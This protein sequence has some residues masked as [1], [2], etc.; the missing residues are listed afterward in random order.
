MSP[1]APKGRVGKCPR[2]SSS[3]AYIDSLPSFGQ[4]VR[5]ADFGSLVSCS[6][7][8]SNSC[9]NGSRARDDHAA[10]EVTHDG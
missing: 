7:L 1:F 8:R 6:N 9:T 2:I 5:L 3:S 4:E 10:P